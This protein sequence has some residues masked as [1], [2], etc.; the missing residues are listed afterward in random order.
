MADKEV[1]VTILT[2]GG[3]TAEW[4]STNPTPKNREFC[5]E[6]TTDGRRK[7]KIGDGTT[8]WNDLPYAS[9]EE[10]ADLTQDATHRTVTDAEKATWN[11]KQDAL[12]FDDAPTAGSN[13]P[14]KSSGI[15][16]ALDA[17]AN[18]ADLA[19][20]AKTGNLADLTQ[21]ATH[22]TVT[23][24]EKATWNAAAGI[25]GEIPT[26]T[27]DLTNDGENGTDKF[28]TESYVNQKTS[29]IYRYKGSVATYADL[30]STHDVGDVYNVVAAYGDYPAGT[31]FA[32]NGTEWDALGGS[33]DL[34]AYVE[35]SELAPIAKSGSLADATQDATHRVVT[36][37]EKAT[38]NAKQSALTFD[39]APTA[40][41]N[42]PVKSGGVKTA[43]DAKANDADLAAIAKSGDLAD[44][45]QDATHRVVTDTE[46]A[47]WNAKQSALTF[48]TTPTAGS[49][50]PVTSG[51]IKT[52]LDAKANSSEIVKTSTGLTDSADLMRYSDTLT[53]NCGG[54]S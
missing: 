42:N 44:A 32:W 6:E 18:D 45:T 17:K 34:S 9:P 15:K 19:T 2:R 28:A 53:I 30:P 29:Q 5:V 13:N 47:T 21:D 40:N 50:N 36:D 24:A 7:F 11:A 37:T 39:D 52:A 22:R 49:T 27:S 33:I 46:K 25:E 20:I 41:S 10:L 43:L 3:T 51:G 54:V 12:T 23:D 38:W 16:T 14:V 1:F 35:E 4:E 26:K 48:D 8:A 31:N